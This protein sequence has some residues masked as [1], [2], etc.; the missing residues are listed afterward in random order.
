[1]SV[2]ELA[3]DIVKMREE[4]K[5]KIAEETRELTEQLNALRTDSPALV[6]QVCNRFI[7]T[8][9]KFRLEDQDIIIKYLE[10]ALGLIQDFSDK[11]SKEL[12]AQA[13]QR[14]KEAEALDALRTVLRRYL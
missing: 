6:G 13:Q 9:Q 3:E 5:R 4:A 1:M 2:L 14:L 12:E 11:H 8:F 10:Q 7:E